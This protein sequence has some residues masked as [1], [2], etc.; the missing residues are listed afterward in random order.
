MQQMQAEMAELRQ[1]IKGLEDKCERLDAEK[2]ELERE[3]NLLRIQI[4]SKDILEKRPKEEEVKKEEEAQVEY[5][6]KPDEIDECEK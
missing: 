1:T 5:E 6:M 4:V 2:A 3:K